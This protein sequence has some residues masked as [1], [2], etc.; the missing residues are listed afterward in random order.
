MHYAIDVLYYYYYACW[1]SLFNIDYWDIDIFAYCRRQRCHADD[2][3]PLRRRALLF[4]ALYL[5][6]LFYLFS[7]ITPLLLMLPPLRYLLM[8]PLL[9]GHY[10]HCICFIDKHCF[11]FIT[12]LLITPWLSR[13]AISFAA[14]DYYAI[15]P[16]FIAAIDIAIYYAIEPFQLSDAAID[17]LIDVISWLF[18]CHLLFRA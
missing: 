3:M 17:P 6:L 12:P 2:A 15:L 4:T 1:L 5:R 10:F 14:I 7:F 18:I 8:P 9:D 13:F 11:I 16:I